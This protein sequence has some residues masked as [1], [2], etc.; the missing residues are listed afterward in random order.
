MNARVQHVVP[1]EGQWAVKSEGSRRL[2]VFS[3]KREAI[4]EA[5]RIAA[6][7]GADLLIHGKMGQIFYRS[8]VESTLDEDVIRQAVRKISETPGRR[9]R[10]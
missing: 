1:H 9:L 6:E 7:T 8:E 10:K 2:T 3:T 4:D 5:R